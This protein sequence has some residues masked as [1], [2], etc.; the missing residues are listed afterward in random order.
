MFGRHDD[1]QDNQQQ[2]DD[3]Q[4][5]TEVITPDSQT[6]DTPMA[7]PVSEPDDDWQHPGTPLDASDTTAP[8]TDMPAPSDTPA[9]DATTAPEVSPEV[10]PE[11]TETP[12]PESA[13]TEPEAPTPEEA[14]PE[15]P[16]APAPVFDV[17]GP[18]GN[19]NPPTPPAD[20]SD[21]G[22]VSHELI[23]IKQQALSQLS[24]LMDHLEQ[25]P[26]EKFHTLMMMIQATDD[27]TLVKEAY[28]AAKQIEDEKVRAQA[29]LDIVNEI[30]YFTQP[31]N[32]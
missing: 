9:D 22:T 17:S 25:S 6:Q 19:F 23:D 15:E 29:L 26:H 31:H 8:A 16:A 30:N 27:Q 4:P 28:D 10:A 13:S 20:D 24:P 14:T 5:A 3:Q 11:A 32:K 1:Q 12:A 7:A 2:V 18:A 21:E